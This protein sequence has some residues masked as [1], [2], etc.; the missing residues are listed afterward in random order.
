MKLDNSENI[1][2]LVPR[3]PFQIRAKWVDCMRRI[4]GNTYNKCQ[5]IA[6]TLRYLMYEKYLKVRTR[7]MEKK[8]FL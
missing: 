5:D 2:V 4:E 3:K 6:E 7:A 8:Y 1:Y